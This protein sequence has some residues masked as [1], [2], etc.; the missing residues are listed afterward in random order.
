MLDETERSVHDAIC[1]VKRVLETNYVVVGGGAVETA[2]SVYLDDFAR[3]LG[4]KE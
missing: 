3:T 4:S 2:L 1:A